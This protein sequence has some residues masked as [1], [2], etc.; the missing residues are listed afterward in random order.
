M[1]CH[2][3]AQVFLLHMKAVKDL[4]KDTT[5]IETTVYLTFVC[6]STI[7]QVDLLQQYILR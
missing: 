3:H 2:D 7:M 5:E 6:I 4:P 1:S